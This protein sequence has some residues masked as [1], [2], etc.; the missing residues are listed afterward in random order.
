M[1]RQTSRQAKA[2]S[3]NL[4]QHL[5][6][7]L[8]S[9]FS[10]PSSQAKPGGG[11][12]KALLLLC[13]SRC[14]QEAGGV[15]CSSVTCGVHVR[16]LVGTKPCMYVY[17]RLRLLAWDVM[18]DCLSLDAPCDAGRAVPYIPTYHGWL[19][20][21]QS[22]G[23]DALRMLRSYGESARYLPTIISPQHQN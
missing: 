12:A 23:P 2:A 1:S 22:Y 21:L 10:F 7:L 15:V 3:N 11:G 5:A 20:G 8:A 4:L 14:I 9:G 6:R 19:S 18:P 17:V 13:Q 16:A